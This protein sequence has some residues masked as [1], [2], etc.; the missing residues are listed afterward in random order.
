MYNACR[1][2]LKIKSAL[3]IDTGKKEEKMEKITKINEH[4]FTA[5]PVL[6][7]KWTK[8]HTARF[9]RLFIR[10]YSPVN[11]VRA[12][13]AKQDRNI[14]SFA[15]IEH[16]K[17]VN[18][19]GTSKTSHIHLLVYSKDGIRLTSLVPYF[20]ENTRLEIP[21]NTFSAFQYLT[22]ANDPSKYQYS[23]Y[24]VVKH[25][26]AG[27]YSVASENA[28]QEA[29]EEANRIW[30]EDV[31]S[32]PRKEL[33]IKYGRDYVRNEDRYRYFVNDILSEA[34]NKSLEQEAEDT[35]KRLQTFLEQTPNNPSQ[36]EQLFGR[37]NLIATS[38]TKYL[39]A[40]HSNAGV[41][42][43]SLRDLVSIV[44]QSLMVA[45]SFSYTGDLDDLDELLN[46]GENNV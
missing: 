27:F 9:R 14:Q 45:E 30:L 19:D 33:A 39:V 22:H 15:Y 29:K 40:L 38:I 35:M 31:Q 37:A 17:D 5:D 20:T 25:S 3:S 26:T 2:L 28:E 18:E 24:E 1:A 11:N 16:N 13:L 7:E 23:P 46:G 36:Y 21:I 12:F 6:T 41:R 10:T 42:Q 34:R 8:S 4:L 43:F 32:L 44:N